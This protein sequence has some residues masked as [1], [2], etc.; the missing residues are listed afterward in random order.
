MIC[1]SDPSSFYSSSPKI[2]SISS[3]SLSLLLSTSTYLSNLAYIKKYV[4][5]GIIK[6]LK[7][8]TSK[9]YPE[10]SSLVLQNIKN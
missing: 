4:S 2:I 3:S 8:N 7:S 6:W 10:L 1:L 5:S 9:A